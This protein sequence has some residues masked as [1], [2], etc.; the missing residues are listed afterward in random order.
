M[1]SW[2]G[3]CKGLDV[4]HRKKTLNYS[5][6]T[7]SALSSFVLALVIHPEVQAKAQQELDSVIGRGRLPD[8]NDRHA[9]PYIN[10]VV[11]EVLR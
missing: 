8:F 1:G 6:Q 4:L 5:S 3:K 9:L 7:V 10:A 11:K 2:S